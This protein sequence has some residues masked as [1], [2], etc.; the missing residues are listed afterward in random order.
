V[1]Q[2]IDGHIAEAERHVR[3]AEQR[4]CR[5]QELVAELARAGHGTEL[6]ERL[7]DTMTVL[8]ATMRDHLSVELGF[9]KRPQSFAGNEDAPTAV[10]ISDV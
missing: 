6:A 5:Q 1:S 3:E 7:L 10:P 9:R 8:L 2:L 4:L